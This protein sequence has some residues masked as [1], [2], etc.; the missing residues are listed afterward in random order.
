MILAHKIALDPTP[1]QAVYFAR[2]SGV[3]RFAW[4]WA[5]AEWQRQYAEWRE[6]QCGPKPSEASLRSELNALKCDAFPWMLEVT[7]TAPQQAIKNLGTA[8]KNFFE[9]RAEY[10][11]FKKKGVSRDSFRAEDGTSKRFPNAVQVDGKRVKLPIIGWIKMCEAVR[12]VGNIKSAIVSRTADRWF[13]SLAVEVDH[14]PPVRETQV[15]GGVDL[16]VKALAT[17]SDGTVIEG[18][19]ALRKSLKILR[20]RSRAHSRKVKGSANRRKSAASLAR[21]HARIANVR[22][23]A[24]HKATT[25]IVRKFDVIG[26]ED[27]NVKGMMANGKLARAVADVGMFEFRRQLEY[28]AAMQGARIVVADRWFPSSRL[29]NACGYVH[30]GLTLKDRE[31]SC[32]NCGVIHDRDGNAANNL[33]DFAAS[34]AVTAC[35]VASSGL[36]R[37]AKVKLTAV[38]QEPTLATK[39]KVTK[40]Q[41]SVVSQHLEKGRAA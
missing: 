33:K 17:L 8:F 25:E 9:G 26:I 7:K 35:G 41:K 24:L 31:W 37:K 6:Y 15:A 12:F 23:D 5:L 36:G 39:N 20:R 32:D 40:R 22:K 28:K 19:K 21:L 18:P 38:K 1:E 13:V 27:L 10:P 3:A 30:A 34:C 14:T 2:A 16:G 4:N 11:R 29:C